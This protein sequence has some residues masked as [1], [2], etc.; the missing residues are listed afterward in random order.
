MPALAYLIVEP[1]SAGHCSALSLVP[2]QASPAPG[3]APPVGGVPA[4]TAA[5]G[6]ARFSTSSVSDGALLGDAWTYFICA[7]PKPPAPNA[8]S[9]IRRG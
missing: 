8:D 1:Q 5:C 9:A 3:A 2:V 6:H 4:A 7:D